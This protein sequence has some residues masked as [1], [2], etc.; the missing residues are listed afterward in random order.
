[1]FDF[2]T[3]LEFKENSTT[4]VGMQNNMRP[5]IEDQLAY[6]DSE[7]LGLNKAYYAKGF[8]S[9]REFSRFD[10][11]FKTRPEQGTNPMADNDKQYPFN[12]TD[13]RHSEFVTAEHVGPK[14]E[15]HSAI[16]ND[17][18]ISSTKPTIKGKSWWLSLSHKVR[19]I[20]IIQFEMFDHR[21]KACFQYHVLLSNFILIVIS[22]YNISSN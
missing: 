1:M 14:I 8:E 13:T 16:L 19:G 20:V 5:Q 22:F 10:E 7:K 17:I 15:N 4:G 21:K 18:D 12:H 3:T 6:Y 9:S 11:R 2:P